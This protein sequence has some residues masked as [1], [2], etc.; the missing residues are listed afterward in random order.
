MDHSK[1][2]QVSGRLPERL[3]KEIRMDSKSLQRLKQIRKN[4]TRKSK[5]KNKDIYRLIDS[6]TIRTYL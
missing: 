4:N 1:G 5:Y 3:L 2:S 6:F